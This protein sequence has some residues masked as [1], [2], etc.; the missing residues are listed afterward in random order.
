MRLLR[1][2]LSFA[3]IWLLAICAVTTSVSAASITITPPKFEYNANPGET[4]R[5]VVKLNNQGSDTLTLIQ[6][7]QD[8]VSSG[9]TGQPSFVDASENNKALSIS[10]WINVNDNR[11]TT[12]NPN[13]N[14][15]VPFTIVIPS[16]A[17]P[18]GHYGAIFFSPPAASGQVAISERIGSLVLVR[19]SGEI[20]E[21]GKLDRFDAYTPTLTEDQILKT[22]SKFFFGSL[23]VTLAMRWE[24][25]GNVHFKPTGK[26]EI[27]NTFGMKV[28]PV[29]VKSVLNER[30]VET[31]KEIVDYIPVNNAQGNVLAK[32][33]RTFLEKW[34]GEP[35][36]F[37]NENGT[38]EIRH[39]GFPIGMYKAVLTLGSGEDATTA[40]THILVL[41]WKEVG[42][43]IVLLAILIFGFPRF[44]KWNNKRL[45][46]KYRK[47]FNVKDTE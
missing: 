46:E 26:I 23:P 6:S 9:E 31:G 3:G 30:G 42:G 43:G 36:W 5:G 13:G 10:N 37:Y 47:K 4:I 1:K 22:S 29:G 38:K 14:V 15:E 32:S 44:R 40:T 18:G 25:Q 39:K 41:P 17:E 28:A 33:F 20:S 24:N 12:I 27:Y 7:I 19:V 35:Y 21:A 11:V 8:F 16:D 34:E 45:E 2:T